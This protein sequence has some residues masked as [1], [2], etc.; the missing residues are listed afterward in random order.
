MKRIK[1]LPSYLRPRERI[2]KEGVE[3]LSI[4]DLIAAIL[5]TGTKGISVLSISAKV[6]KLLKSNLLMKSSLISLGIGPSKTA[7]ILAA[8][9][10]GKRLG[11]SK[12]I[13]FPSAEHVFAHAYEIIKQEKESLLCLYLNAR[14]ELLK[15][16]VLV[17]GSLNRVQLQPREIFSVIKELPVAAIIM[18]HNHPSGELDPSKDDILFTKRV[19]AAADIL[20]IKLLDHLVVS[21]KGWKRIRP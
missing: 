10:L 4:E 21:E 9:E 13:V 12:K 18:A 20:G 5:I 14:G 16:E 15:K 2:L 17:V 11:D 19:K 3:S 6:A 8:V 7:Q 1:Y